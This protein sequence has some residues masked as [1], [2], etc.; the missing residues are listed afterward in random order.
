MRFLH[1]GDWQ[2]GMRAAHVGAAGAAV[3]AARLAALQRLVALAQEHRAEFILV[4]GDSFEHHGVDRVLVQQVADLAGA[5]PGPIFLIPGNHDPLGPGSVWEHPAWS[6]RRNLTICTEA[7]PL[8]IPGGTLFPCPLREKHSFDD[9]T[10]WIDARAAAGIRLGLAH[11]TVQG[12]PVDEPDHPIARDAAS[13]AGLDYLALGHWHSFASY[14]AASGAVRMAYCGSHETTKFGERDSGRALLVE[15][16]APGSVPVIT[17]LQTGRLTWEKR[18]A[19]I[20]RAGDLQRLREEIE[21]LDRPEFR[22]LDLRLTGLL[23]AVEM[24]EIPRIEELCRARFL[25]A[26]IDADGL[27]PRPEDSA[28]IESLPPGPVRE[29]GRELQQLSDGSFAGPAREGITADGAT[30]ALLALY[31]LAATHT[32]A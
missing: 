1:T 13:R 32:A 28:W 19:E 30:H 29:A 10:R 23:A 31:Q 6:A 5:F 22:L 25:F 24:S 16:A 11:G 26:R 15:I 21:T 8:E 20:A 14:P 4:A 7:R 12:V 27:R 18:D 17:P 9:P 3:R 2:M